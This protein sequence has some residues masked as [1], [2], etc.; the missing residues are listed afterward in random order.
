MEEPGEVKGEE[1]EEGEGEPTKEEGTLQLEEDEVDL[2]HYHPAGGPIMMEILTLPTPPKT[3]G[4]W[5]IRKGDL[6]QQ[7]QFDSNQ[8]EDP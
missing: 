1:R 2:R 4:Q 7:L 5:T 8:M 6:S 3:V